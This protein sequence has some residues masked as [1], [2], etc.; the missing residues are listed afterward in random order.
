M[1]LLQARRPAYLAHRI[2]PLLH[3]VSGALAGA[4]ETC[5]K[6]QLSGVSP[7]RLQSEPRAHGKKPGDGILSRS[8]DQGSRP[9]WLQPAGDFI[10]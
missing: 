7:R 8:S 10:F 6:Y 4:G 1:E 3:T 5:R 9:L 2:E